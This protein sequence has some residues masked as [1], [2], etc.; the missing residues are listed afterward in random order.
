MDGDERYSRQQLIPGWDQLKLDNSSVV[1]VGV[2]A[3]GSYVATV[4]VSSGIG[5]LTIIDFDTI[6]ALAH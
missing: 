3:I 5:K 2:G 6:R 1:L 4:L